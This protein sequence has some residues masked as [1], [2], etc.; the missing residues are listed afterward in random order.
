MTTASIM[1]FSFGTSLVERRDAIVSV[2]QDVSFSWMEEL[3]F[4][5][6]IIFNL[7]AG[8]LFLSTFYFFKFLNVNFRIGL[9]W[10]TLQRASTDLA[11]FMVFFF[12][13]FLGFVA[14]GYLI[15]GSFHC[16]S[17]ARLQLGE[18]N[19]VS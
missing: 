12:I 8:C 4:R 17:T 10:R 18:I 9:L 2:N 3:G 15:F 7:Y 6:T 14:S 5:W 19:A 11:S 13:I 16:Y 1:Y